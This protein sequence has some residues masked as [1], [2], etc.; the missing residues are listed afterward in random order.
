MA[1]LKS[2]QKKYLLLMILLGVFKFSDAQVLGG[3]FSQNAT[4]KEY[5]IAQIGLLQ[6]YLGYVKKGYDIAKKGLTLIGD[7]KQEDFNLHNG[8]FNS[9]E[10]V[11]PKLKSD[12]R[13]AAIIG[14]QLNVLAGY[15]SF[16]HEFK[17]SGVFTGSELDYFDR[18]FALLLDDVAFG[19]TTLTDLL[20]DGKFKMGD[21]ERTKR[22]NELYNGASEQYE[23][24]NGFSAQVKLQE[25]QRKQELFETGKI[26]K[27]Y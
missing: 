7:I 4:Q 6:T 3:I 16:S 10:T 13:V 18:V 22:M 14:I 15:R 24:F 11:S 25:M 26:Q 17:E 2:I 9:L 20:T 1:C 8:F 19:V 21:A 12:A 27:M 23:F 5:M